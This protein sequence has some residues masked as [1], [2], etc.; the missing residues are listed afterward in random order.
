MDTLSNLGCRRLFDLTNKKVL[1]ITQ[2]FY[3]EIGSAGNRMK[4][5]YQLLKQEGYEVTVLTTEPSYPNKKIYKEKKFWY[6]C[7][8]NEDENIHRVSVRNRKYSFSM[9]N[10][11]LYYVEVALKMIIFVLFDRKKYNQVFVS[12]P[13]IFIGFVGL[14]AKYRYRA[15]MILDIR[16]LWPE[17]LKGVGV[18]NS[19]LIIW[20]F[21]LFEK[22]LYKKANYIIVNSIGFIDY[23][24]RKLKY[25]KKK[26]T[27][28][29]NSARISELKEKLKNVDNK[30]QVIY[31]GNL[32]LAQDVTFLKELTLKLK[33][34][35]IHF[36]IVGY[37]LRK[38]EL[39][40]FVKSNKLTN[41]RFYNPT[42]REECLTLNRENDVGLLSL[43]DKEVFD[44]VLPGKLVDY[45]ITGLP[46][47]AAVS[48]NSK[49]TIE[50]YDVGFVSKKR[51]VDEIIHYILC[52]KNNP[53]LSSKKSANCRR[54]IESKFIWEK[55][56]SPLLNILEENSYKDVFIPSKKIEKVENNG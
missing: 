5:I 50:K 45:M 23:I 49:Q 37:G 24:N 6:D 38:K 1:L 13:P 44:T 28:I 40:H 21:S 54:L 16:D 22:I 31:T 9:F 15:K 8:L 35:N 32:G 17:S 46:I 19:R 18:F 11:L 48:G 41:V 27:F 56:I 25:R 47:V 4:N 30:F 7:S 39:I 51:D 42:T 36:N 2:N 33:E 34:H 55:N 10:R 52:L 12:S 26:I 43:N 53:E 14:I 3:P 20:I 29:P